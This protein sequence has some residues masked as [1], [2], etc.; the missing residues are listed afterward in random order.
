MTHIATVNYSDRIASA[1]YADALAY[2]MTSEQLIHCVDFLGGCSVDHPAV[3][4]L[5]QR[6]E[7]LLDDKAAERAA[8]ESARRAKRAIKKYG[9]E[10]CK[11]AYDLHVW[12][13]GASGISHSILALNGNTRA[14]DSAI[15]AGRWLAVNSTSNI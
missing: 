4:L 7:K 9:I 8:K 12:G 14:A 15:D 6:F 2:Y 13:Y 3:E 1:T 5:E 10:V 11:E